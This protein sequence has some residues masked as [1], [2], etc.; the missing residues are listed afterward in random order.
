MTNETFVVTR[1]GIT[2]APASPYRAAKTFSNTCG[3]IVR[4]HV[5][6]TCPD[7]KSLTE[8][9]KEV[10][11]DKLWDRYVV[12]EGDKERV[13]RKADSIMS[14]ALRTWRY[15][16]KKLLTA[17]FETKIKT[18]W[19]KIEREHWEQ[20]VADKNSEAF[21]QKSQQGKELRA[22]NKWPHHLGS[23]G[24]P[25][26]KP[27]WDKEDAALIAAGKPVPFPDI[28]QERARNYLRARSVPDPVT[29]SP[30]ITDPELQEVA[31]RLVKSQPNLY[32]FNSINLLV[33]RL[34]I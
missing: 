10:L 15:D 17:D 29:G 25:G 28:V 3:C 23:R 26:K 22:K 4:D 16:A 5:R 34:T 33:I 32:S 2:G 13:R 11:F 1:V 7:Y 6:I 9:Q 14:A 30:A 12:P 18:K 21:E 19:P 24:F 27:K 31:A 8:A 20:F